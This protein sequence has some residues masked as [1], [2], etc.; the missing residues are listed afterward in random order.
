MVMSQC[1]ASLRALYPYTRLAFACMHGRSLAGP[2]PRGVGCR[3]GAV[4]AMERLW[5]HCSAETSSSVV[6]VWGRWTEFGRALGIR[7]M[8][9]QAAAAAGTPASAMWLVLCSTMHAPC[10]AM[11]EGPHLMQVGLPTLLNS[12]SI[13]L[14]S[15]LMSP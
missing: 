14:R 6:A 10:N 7:S 13:P 4:L 11:G 15:P 5:R 3:P 12:P 9:W 8:C 1:H 2:L